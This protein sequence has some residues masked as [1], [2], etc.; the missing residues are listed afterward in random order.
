MLLESRLTKVEDVYAFITIVENAVDYYFSEMKKLSSSQIVQEDPVRAM[1]LKDTYAKR[2]TSLRGVLLEAK[3]MQQR[4]M[5]KEDV[6]DS[7]KAS[8]NKNPV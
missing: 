8:K 4:I 5:S 1:Q 2:V 7:T 3:A 6:F